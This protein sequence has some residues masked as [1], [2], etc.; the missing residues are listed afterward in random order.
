[1]PPD[2][3]IAFAR[4]SPRRWTSWAFQSAPALTPTDETQLSSIA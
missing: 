1:M 3:M 2:M 4:R